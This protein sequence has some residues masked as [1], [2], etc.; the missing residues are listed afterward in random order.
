M[1]I[2]KFVDQK[3]TMKKILTLLIVLMLGSANLYSQQ[4][5]ITSSPASPGSNSYTFIM[6]GN[7]SP[8][9][10]IILWNFGDGTWGFGPAANHTYNING[11][12]L[13]N[14]TIRLF[15]DTTN[16]LCSSYDSVTISG[17]NPAPCAITSYPDSSGTGTI[18]FFANNVT[19]GNTITWNFGDGGTGTGSPISHTYNQT[20]FY[21]V[22][23]SSGIPGTTGYCTVTDSVYA[24]V[25]TS[26]GCPFSYLNNS[27]SQYAFYPLNPATSGNSYLISFGD[28]TSATNNSGQFTHEYAT[29]GLYTVSLITILGSDTC[30]SSQVIEVVTN[31]I[32]S[33]GCVITYT[34][35]NPS[36]NTYL[37][38]LSSVPVSASWTVI[39]GNSILDT[40]MLL[41]SNTYSYSFPGAGSYLISV[42]T[43][44]TMGNSCSQTISVTVYDSTYNCSISYNVSDPINNVYVF[45]IPSG[46]GHVYWQIFQD[47][48]MVDSTFTS[49]PNLVYTFPSPGTYTVMVMN[50][51]TSDINY[52]LV[53]TG[54]I[55]VTVG[56]NPNPPSSCFSDFDIF[57]DN[58]TGFFIESGNYDPTITNYSWSFGDG[59]YSSERYPY[60][61]YANP[62]TYSVSLLIY[63]VLCQDTIIKMITVNNA[64][65]DSCNAYFT[66]TQTAPNTLTLVSAAG[67]FNPG[68]LLWNFGNGI[69]STADFPSLIVPYN[70]VNLICLSINQPSCINSY[71]DTVLIDSLGN[72]NRM[73]NTNVLINVVSPQNITGYAVTISINNVSDNQ[74]AAYPNPFT[75][76]FILENNQSTYNLYRIFG[77]D[78][79]L[80]DSGNLHAGANRLN[81]AAWAQGS[82]LLQ[83][84]GMK[85]EIKNMRISKH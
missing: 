47:S 2:C 17:L 55:T 57:Q 54:N 18:G 43:M 25:S 78:G 53:C 31:V 41:N 27:N 11:T 7:W 39:Q 79:K 28:G 5:S 16:V 35:T 48:A 73:A 83:L 58:L 46:A 26:P 40:T 61:T 74:L 37:F 38:S 3:N 81:G 68:G 13:V 66:V 21:A 63:N 70:S 51:D 9:Q 10:Y 23:M 20:G 71:C 80:I 4:C 32:D 75:D 45:N 1:Q 56:G 24:F 42:N 19:P 12:F 50:Y 64:A 62:G 49:Q 77:I 14:L 84:T 72:L 30:Q 69:S 59:G 34:N 67:N 8:V 76:A 60:H 44:D 52:T 82:Y 65:A 15:S 36:S 29:A 33:T 22:T 85:G 6:N